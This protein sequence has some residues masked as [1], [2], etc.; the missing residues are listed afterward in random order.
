MKKYIQIAWVYF[1]LAWSATAAFVIIMVA[2]CLLGFFVYAFCVKVHS[3]G[4]SW[5]FGGIALGT[6]ITVLCGK[7]AWKYLEHMKEQRI[8]RER[9]ETYLRDGQP[10]I[11]STQWK[12]DH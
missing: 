5:W 8:I 6:A 3:M 1:S 10:V 4:F 11:R 7:E 12:K 9:N 2:A